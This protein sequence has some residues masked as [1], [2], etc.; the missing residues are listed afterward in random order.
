MK[1]N[2]DAAFVHKKD[3]FMHRIIFHNI[4]WNQRDFFFLR[5]EAGY[6]KDKSYV[7]LTSPN[8]ASQ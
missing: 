4:I 5:M 8:K 6:G 3:N 2:D 1:W 7:R